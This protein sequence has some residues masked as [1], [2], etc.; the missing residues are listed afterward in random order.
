VT[1]VRVQ[2]RY[3]D[4]PRPHPSHKWPG[5]GLTATPTDLVQLTSALM[6]GTFLREETVKAMWTPQETGNGRTHPMG[7]GMGWATGSAGDR[8]GLADAVPTVHHGCTVEGGAAF[9]LLLPN[10][11][12]AVSAMT[13]LHLGPE[14]SSELRDAVYTLAGG[15]AR[16][17]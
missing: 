5:G 3:V 13:N 8:L 11:G 1:Y 15:L 2:N 6:G 4:P 16:R 12:I 10:Q 9:L 7:Y 17:S 14:Q